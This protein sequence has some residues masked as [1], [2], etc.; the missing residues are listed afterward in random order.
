MTL[1]ITRKYLLLAGIVAL[2]AAGLAIWGWQLRAAAAVS[3]DLAA[4]VMPASDGARQVADAG[5]AYDVV[6]VTGTGTATGNP[7]LATVALRVSVTAN[8]VTEARETAAATTR[9]VLDALQGNGVAYSDI[10]TNRFTI[11]T[12]YDWSE[13]QQTFVGYTVTNG[14]E[15]TVRDV[16]RLGQIIDD[17][18]TA[19]DEY[20]RF[21]A[22]SFGF[23]DTAAMERQ[24]RQAAVADMQGK[25]AQLAEFAGRELGGLKSLAEVD[26]A[27]APGPYQES[28]LARAYASDAEITPVAPGEDTVVVVV[29]GVYELQ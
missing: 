28:L 20:I 17:A 18:V 11:H 6:E 21:D 12:E 23:A 26:L 1:R 2:L 14:L 10:R 22:V 3:D 4:L 8:P 19:G 16:G 27:G 7:D 25:A 29:Y 24:A 13:G 5:A 9:Q 15:A